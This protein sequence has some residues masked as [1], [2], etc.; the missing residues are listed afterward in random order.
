M[1]NPSKAVRR[2]I[3][4]SVL[5]TCVLAVASGAATFQLGSSPAIP[6]AEGKVKLRQT[7]SGNTEIQLEVKHLAPPARI[8][9]T[10]SV[11]VVWVRGLEAGAL[12][13]NLG[14]LRTNK[15]LNGKLKS[16][17]SL[18][19][20]DLF[21]TAEGTQTVTAPTTTELMP[22]HYTGKH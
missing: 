10:T 21:L 8:N 2:G 5:L 14:A 17:T 6:A 7:S 9:P 16:V 19:E 22:F 3:V 12:P 18:R 15:N 1:Q 4:I 13:Q 11:F 20:F